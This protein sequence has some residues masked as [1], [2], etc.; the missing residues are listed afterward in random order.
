LGSAREVAGRNSNP[1]HTR[2][3]S[4]PTIFSLGIRNLR[5][6]YFSSDA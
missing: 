2:E 1:T 5:R 3:T 6:Y 4:P